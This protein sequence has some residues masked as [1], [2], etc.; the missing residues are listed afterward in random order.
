MT[1]ADLDPS[2]DRIARAGMSSLGRD[3][4]CLRPVA[5][6]DTVVELDHEPEY[7]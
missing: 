5:I 3:L 6:G 2:W 7:F 1:R 4:P